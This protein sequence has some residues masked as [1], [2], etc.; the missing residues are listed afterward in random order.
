MP[1]GFISGRHPNNNHKPPLLL[2]L[3]EFPMPAI[4]PGKKIKRRKSVRNQSTESERRAASLEQILR[5]SFPEAAAVL[6][7]RLTCSFQTEGGGAEVPAGPCVSRTRTLCSAVQ[8]L[9]FAEGSVRV[10]L[11]NGENPSRVY[12][13]VLTQARGFRPRSGR[14]VSIFIVLFSK[15]FNGL[16]VSAEMRE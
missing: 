2:Q 1:I 10:R 11:P 3:T 5:A 7:H 8:S 9:G 14:Q 6:S 15:P 4:K 13:V 16:S 12:E